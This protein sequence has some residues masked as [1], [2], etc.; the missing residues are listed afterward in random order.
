M[1]KTTPQKTWSP[2]KETPNLLGV[3][4][5]FITLP[6]AN[7]APEN[8][9]LEFGMA[10][11]QR[12]CQFQGGYTFLLAQEMISHFKTENSMFFFDKNTATKTYQRPAVQHECHRYMSSVVGWSNKT[13]NK[14]E[15][16]P[17]FFDSTNLSIPLRNLLMNNFMKV[18][19]LCLK[20]WDTPSID[21]MTECSPAKQ[22]I[23]EIIAGNLNIN[24]P[25]TK[26]NRP[27]R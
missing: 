20:R 10:Y 23:R 16:I 1:K 11:F 17:S 18:K 5:G 27:P 26:T 3:S 2:E 12:L 6:E 24:K 19:A 9:W 22:D 15:K 13:E 14:M 8:W 25:A 7:I 21:N 4:S